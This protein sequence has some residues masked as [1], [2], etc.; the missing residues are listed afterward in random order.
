[1]LK[2]TLFAVACAI[3]WGWA[4]FELLSTGWSPCERAG[5]CGSEGIVVAIV[6]L[7]LPTQVAVAAYLRHREKEQDRVE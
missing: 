6:L 3:S 7:L 4:I 5:T 2:W 1:M